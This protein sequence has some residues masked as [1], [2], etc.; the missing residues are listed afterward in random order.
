MARTP[1]TVPSDSD[2]AAMHVD[3]SSW[4][5]RQA[6]ERARRAAKARKGSGRRRWVDPATCD[7]EYSQAEVE[8]MQAMQAYKTESGRTYPTWGEV[9]Q[10]ISRL[11]YQKQAPEPTPEAPSSTTTG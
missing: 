11:G 1:N 10:V 6:T 5:D 3:A 8:F 7:R 4:V 9:L 2:S